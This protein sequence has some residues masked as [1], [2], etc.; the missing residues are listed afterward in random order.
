MSVESLEDVSGHSH[1]EDL[2]IVGKKSINFRWPEEATKIIM[3]GVQNHAKPN[4]I[5]RNLKHANVF[6]RDMP[7]K[8]QLYNKIAATK[9]TV[10][11]SSSIRNTH[12]L[13]MKLAEFLDEPASE[14]E[15][16]VPYHDIEDVDDNKEPRFNIIFSTRKNLS[17]LRSNRVLQTDATYR[18][19]WMGFPVYVVGNN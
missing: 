2:E 6:G 19:N 10:F 4:V 14:L 11:P 12:E 8:V 17:K 3:E 1:E 7:T 9:L 5:K 15:A 16:F 13:R 18:L